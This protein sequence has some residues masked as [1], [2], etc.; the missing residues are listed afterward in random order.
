[1]SSAVV[2]LCGDAALYSLD[3]NMQPDGIRLN[4]HLYTLHMMSSSAVNL[5]TSLYYSHGLRGSPESAAMASPTL[6]CCSTAA[7]CYMY[8][9]YKGTSLTVRFPF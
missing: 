8:L 9:L 6:C 2:S 1:M 7:T 4:M 3:K 5:N